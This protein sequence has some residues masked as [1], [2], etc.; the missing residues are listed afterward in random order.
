MMLLAFMHVSKTDDLYEL[1]PCYLY[2]LIDKLITFTMIS[3]EL[4]IETAIKPSQG[5]K[6]Y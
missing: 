4:K 5:T 2:K 3:Y 6:R 1:S